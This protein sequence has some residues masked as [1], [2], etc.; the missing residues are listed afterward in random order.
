[1]LS[2]RILTVAQ[3][4]ETKEFLNKGLQ[5][6][7]TFLPYKFTLNEYNYMKKR[8]LP[9]TQHLLTFCFEAKTFSKEFLHEDYF[10][11][12]AFDKEKINIFF[13]KNIIKKAFVDYLQNDPYNLKIFWGINNTSIERNERAF[14]DEQQC[15]DQTGQI[16][17]EGVF[18]HILRN[19]VTSELIRFN[20]SFKDVK[21]NSNTIKS[22]VVAKV[23]FIEDFE[24]LSSYFLGSINNINS[25]FVMEKKNINYKDLKNMQDKDLTEKEIRKKKYIIELNKKYSELF[26]I[27]NKLKKETPLFERA[28]FLFDFNHI[29]FSYFLNYDTSF[30]FDTGQD[31]NYVLSDFIL[32]YDIKHIFSKNM[33]IDRLIKVQFIKKISEIFPNLKVSH[34]EKILDIEF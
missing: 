16:H 4:Y 31:E 18:C 14:F 20:I 22:R 8:F 12:D 5:E 29:M 34:L 15:Y 17:A 2:H 1:M 7:L 13:E 32:E 3:K 27:K 23:G 25:K 6:L 11:Y 21:T 30:F 19:E 24:S 10:R 26:T 9:L 28:A 33:T